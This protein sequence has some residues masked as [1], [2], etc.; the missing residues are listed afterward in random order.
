M[1]LYLLVLLDE[2]LGPKPVVAEQVRTQLLQ[3]SEEEK[4]RQAVEDRV[5]GGVPCDGLYSAWLSYSALDFSDPPPALVSAVNEG[6]LQRA[7]FDLML[8]QRV[9]SFKLNYYSEVHMVRSWIKDFFSK[10]CVYMRPMPDTEKLWWDGINPLRT[11]HSGWV[12][13]E[14][15]EKGSLFSVL[16]RWIGDSDHLQQ[17]LSTFEATTLVVNNPMDE[18]RVF[19]QTTAQAAMNWIQ[20]RLQTIA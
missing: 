12:S 6:T 11:S 19:S 8:G 2:Y 20:V 14:L 4:V 18:N 7:L 5:K 16:E 13:G 9:K 1:E 17:Q 10:Q 15:K 3:D